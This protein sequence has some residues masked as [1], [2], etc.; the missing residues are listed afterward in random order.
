MRLHDAAGPH[1]HPQHVCLCRDVQRRDDSI[2]VLK[3]TGEEE[4]RKPSNHSKPL[5]C[6]QKGFTHFFKAPNYCNHLNSP[7]HK[8]K[9]S[10]K[11]LI[12]CVSLL[13]PDA[14]RRQRLESHLKVPRNMSKLVP[15]FQKLMLRHLAGVNFVELSHQHPGSG[16][17]GEHWQNSLLPHNGNLPSM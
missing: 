14:R 1:P 4:V 8:P 3:E 5:G 9:I 12:E 2:H 17:A 11:S 7:S 6:F 10:P 13:R 15:Y 16:H